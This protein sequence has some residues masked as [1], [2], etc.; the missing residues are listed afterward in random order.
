[1][2]E[3]KVRVNEGMVKKGNT[4]PPPAQSRPQ[5]PKGQSSSASGGS[6]KQG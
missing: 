3:R 2:S 5:A 1:M 6:T 4:S